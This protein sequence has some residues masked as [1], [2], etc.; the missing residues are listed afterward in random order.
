MPQ[1]LSLP[2]AGSIDT[3]PAS[4]VPLSRE[5]LRSR[6]H[7]VTRARTVS[8]SR[9]P[10]QEL[11]AGRQLYPAAEH[12]DVVRPKTRADCAS[13]PRPCPFVSC[14]HHNYLDVSAKTGAIKLNFPDIEPWELAPSDSCALDVADKNGSTLEEVG[15]IMNLTR[16]RIRQ[17]EV[18]S[19]AKL[20]AAK[21]ME[22]LRE[23]HGDVVSERGRRRLPIL[24]DDG[25]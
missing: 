5:Q 14:V 24:R 8:C 1:Q 20:A 13:I 25:C 10:K 15:R 18:R 22:A 12:A 23:F 19:L 6:R 2:I 11:E 7:R 16:E 3:V 9:L 17:V 4:D 21:E